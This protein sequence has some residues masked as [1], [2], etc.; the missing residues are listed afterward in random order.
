MSKAD[1]LWWDRDKQNW[2]RDPSADLKIK[3]IEA[4]EK[5]WTITLEGKFGDRIPAAVAGYLS[6]FASAKA[7][8]LSDKPTLV[9][10]Q[11]SLLFANEGHMPGLHR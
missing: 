3:L 2:K 6:W 10:T 4:K 9:L 11:S 7:L 1:V 8:G 5:F